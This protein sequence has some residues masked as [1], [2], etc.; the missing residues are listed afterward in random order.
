MKQERQYKS[1]KDFGKKALKQQL[2]SSG[3]RQEEESI[4]GFWEALNGWRF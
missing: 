3:I 1:A 4:L 2:P